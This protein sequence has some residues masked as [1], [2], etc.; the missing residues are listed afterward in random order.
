[1]PQGKVK[2]FSAKKGYGFIRD[3]EKDRDI[4]LH[5]SSIFLIVKEIWKIPVFQNWKFSLGLTF[6]GLTNSKSSTPTPSAVH[7]WT[8]LNVLKL[9]SKTSFAISSVSAF[10]SIT[11][12]IWKILNV[13]LYQWIASWMDGT[14]IPIWFTEVVINL[15]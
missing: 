5:V 7:I 4:F 14:E 11:S 3:E 6:F 1:M 15:L 8:I 13:A 10:T 2:W 12:E 9:F